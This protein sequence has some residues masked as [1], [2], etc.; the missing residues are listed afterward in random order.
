MG[1][2]VASWILRGGVCA[3]LLVMGGCTVSVVTNPDFQRSVRG[4]GGH[5]AVAGKAERPAPPAT[6]PPPTAPGQM[7]ND[8]V[9]LAVVD[10]RVCP[11][12][13]TTLAVAVA[14]R[15]A[16]VGDRFQGSEYLGRSGDVARVAFRYLERGESKAVVFDYHLGTGIVNGEDLV[17]SESLAALRAECG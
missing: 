17:G 8:G 2:G 4:G 7:P 9:R 10:Y 13:P 1:G 11:Q 3:L 14:A 5:R 6:T 12:Q 16:A 15:I